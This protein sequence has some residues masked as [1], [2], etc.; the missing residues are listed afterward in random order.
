[1]KPLSLS[2]PLI[3]SFVETPDC[4]LLALRQRQRL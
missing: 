1:M 4:H 2:I 3:I